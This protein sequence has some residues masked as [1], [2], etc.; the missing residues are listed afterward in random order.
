MVDF[1]AIIYL[2][3]V[4]VLA[5]QYRVNKHYKGVGWWLLWSL[6]EAIGFFFLSLRELN[7]PFLIFLQNAFLFYGTVFMYMGIITFFGKTLNRG[8]LWPVFIVYSL[9]LVF[10]LTVH[11]NAEYRG[12]LVNFSTGIIGALSARALFTQ[13][14]ASIRLSANFTAV[15]LS[16]HSLFML[17]SSFMKLA[18]HSP[19]NPLIATPINYITLIDAMLI[20][21]LITFGFIIML[22]HRLNAILGETVT[23]LS[24]AEARDRELV[25]ALEKSNNEKDTFYSVLAHD[26]RSP[27]NSLLGLTNILKDEFAALEPAEV[28]RINA[29]VQH[30]AEKLYNLVENLLEWSRT[31]RGMIPFE[32][33]ALDL[34]LQTEPVI[35]PLQGMMEAKSISLLNEIPE[36]LAVTADKHMLETILRNLLVNS[37]K[38][39]EKGGQIA[40]SAGPAEEGIIQVTVTD[41]GIGMKPEIAAK[42]FH[43]D[44]D[45]T[46]KGTSGESGTG[47]G[48]IICY[49]FVKKLGGRIWLESTEGKGSSFCFTLPAGR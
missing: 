2:I 27:F 3:Q 38:F 10:L 39:T 11:D 14:P 36:G 45:N 1:L 12:G 43:L 29:T 16:L 20:S 40:V 49:E 37:I 6:S 4:L 18:G 28:T 8:F 41:T 47:L 34:G 9:L 15:V 33:E 26:L 31:Q 48:L 17:Y 21:L 13:R 32:P 30:S 7:N 23:S 5:L 24:E 19:G 44:P 25:N 35:Q 22:N 42:A 46:R